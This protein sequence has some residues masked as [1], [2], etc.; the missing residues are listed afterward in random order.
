MAEERHKCPKCGKNTAIFIQP[1]KN[2]FPLGMV[3]RRPLLKEICKSCKHIEIGLA[4]EMN[5]GPRHL[6]PDKLGPQFG[7]Q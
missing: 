6:H 4:S 5:G 2:D 7:D 1:N 3:I